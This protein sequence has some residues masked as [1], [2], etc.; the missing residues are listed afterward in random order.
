MMMKNKAALIEL[1]QSWAICNGF[2]LKSQRGQSFQSDPIPFTLTPTGIN[3]KAYEK[4]VSIAPLLNTLVDRMSRDST[5]INQSLESVAKYDDFVKRLLDI[6]NE[7]YERNKNDYQLAVHRSDYMIHVDGKSGQEIPQQVE[8]NTVSSAFGAL[9]ATTHKLHS[10]LQQYRSWLVPEYPEQ[11]LEPNNSLE[12]IVN[13]MRQ[14]HETFVQENPSNFGSMPYFMLFVV[15]DGERN[16][17]DQKPYEH[18]LLQKYGIFVLRRS[19]KELIGNVELV[20]DEKSNRQHLVIEK[21]YPVSVV[22]FR[23]GYTP[24]DFPT[25]NEWEVR[26]VLETCTAIK[27]PTIGVQLVGTKK[28]QQ[29]MF[30]DAVLQKYLTKEEAQSVKE[31]FTGIYSLEES[32]SLQYMRE[33]FENPDD[34]VLKP[35]REGGGNLVYGEK[36]KE[37]LDI[38][39]HDKSHT[40]YASIKYTYILMK[41]I[42]PQLHNKDII[43]QGQVAGGECISELGIYGIYL[44]NGSQEL[45]NGSA[46][47]LLRTKLAKFQD[48]GVASGVASMD[49]IYL[50]D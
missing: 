16:V 33:A 8:L 19:M 43:R 44:G 30:E 13:V 20:K 29:I 28:I 26:S 27:C 14:S 48:G 40:E 22:Y 5:F 46:G 4:V 32:E 50:R 39:L 47:Y 2:I 35:Q 23:S 37:Y 42:K 1:A 11:E 25:E 15:Q 7:T 34:Y 38:I 18:L 21:Q 36:L 10:Y 49:S 3:R 31:A 45:T 9:G 6:Y 12:N 41:K 17:G 24:D